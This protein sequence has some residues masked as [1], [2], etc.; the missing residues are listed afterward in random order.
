MSNPDELRGRRSA[1]LDST[2]S[3]LRALRAGE[4]GAGDR[5][6]E[7]MRPAL[8]RWAHRRMP[9]ESR[10]LQDT[11]DIVQVTLVR[12]FQ[13]LDRFEAA[14]PGALLGYARQILFN[15]LRDEARRT[16]RRPRTSSIEE[17]W[18]PPDPAPSALDLAVGAETLRRYESALA[19]LRSDQR[20]AVLLRIELKYTYAE[21]AEALELVSAEAARKSVARS[22]ARLAE[23]MR[24]GE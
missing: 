7:R 3:L 4:P 1:P 5:L 11:E 19:A 2:S 10:S 13:G 14:G 23:V 6:I 8:I 20:E 17:D 18:S 9:L 21:I 15:A 24:D 16:A 22:L 12:T